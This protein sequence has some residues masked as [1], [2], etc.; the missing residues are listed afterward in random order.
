MDIPNKMD[1]F[2]NKSLLGLNIKH[3]RLNAG[4]TQIEL[5][6][7]IGVK[8]TALS[9]WEVG[10][11]SPDMDILAKISN[12]FGISVDL[13][14]FT[15]YSEWDGESLTVNSKSELNV[16]ICE[17][18]EL[19]QKIIDNQ[20]ENIKLL[21]DKINQLERDSKDKPNDIRQTG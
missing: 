17:R 6:K 3:L 20:E 2:F 10:S 11:A 8:G 16:D 18:C 4:L 21:K 1:K 13:L 19:R 14:A 9:N 7:I 15:E 12:Y 5:S